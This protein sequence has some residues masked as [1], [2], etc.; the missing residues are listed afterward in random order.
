VGG[1]FIED[2]VSMIKQYRELQM[3]PSFLSISV[4]WGS[5]TFL[6]SA[7]STVNGVYIATGP[8]TT[9][10]PEVEAFKAEFKKD[11]GGEALPYN[12]TAYDNVQL[13]LAA[14]KKAGTSDPEKVSETMRNFEYKGLLQTYRFNNSNQSEVVINVNEVK[15]GKISVISSIVAK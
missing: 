1:A 13:V 2:G 8:T 5:P 14:M 4:I 7:G 3:S 11:T 15:E 12:I 9:A 6:R 10:S